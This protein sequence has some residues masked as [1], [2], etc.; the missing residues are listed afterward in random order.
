MCTIATPFINNVTRSPAIPRGLQQTQ[1]LPYCLPL[2][3]FFGVGV[4]CFPEI[5]HLEDRVVPQAVLSFPMVKQLVL[6]GELVVC[7]ILACHDAPAP[8]L[9]AQ[10]P[11]EYAFCMKELVGTD[12]IQSPLD[13]HAFCLQKVYWN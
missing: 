4:L 9:L 5:S 12:D 6:V 1:Q 7:H 10:P 11:N 2:R 13:E 3:R 8:F